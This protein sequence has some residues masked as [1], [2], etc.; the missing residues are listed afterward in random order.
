LGTA[1]DVGIFNPDEKVCNRPFEHTNEKYKKLKLFFGI[2]YFLW[3]LFNACERVDTLP[4][5]AIHFNYVFYTI[6]AV[7]SYC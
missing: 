1:F 3:I 5:Y 2:L 6:S 4:D 7:F